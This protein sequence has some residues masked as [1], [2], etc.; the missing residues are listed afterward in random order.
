MNSAK[1]I[2]ILQF[3]LHQKSTSSEQSAKITLNS[4]STFSDQ[5]SSRSITSK[6]EKQ[7]VRT[8]VDYEISRITFVVESSS[9]SNMSQEFIETQRRELMTMMQEF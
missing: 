7:T 9:A 8:S 3:V 5:F 1:S 4:N 6:S 2:F